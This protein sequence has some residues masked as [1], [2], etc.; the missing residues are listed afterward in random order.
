MAIIAIIASTSSPLMAT[1]VTAPS[2]NMNI[3]ASTDAA[4]LIQKSNEARIDNALA[5][6]ATSSTLMK[7]AQLKAEHMAKNGY[8]AHTS[9]GG[10]NP[11]HWFYQA[12][13]KPRY[14]GENLALTYTLDAEIVASWLESPAHKKNLLGK[15]YKEI[16]IG[17]AK[18]KYQGEDAYYVVQLL[19]TAK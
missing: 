8:F 2:S 9:P 14:A 11:W 18:G 13:Y 5:E 3:A 12:G 1:A 4:K 16:G 6:L 10:I 17:I 7:A 15:N 19:G